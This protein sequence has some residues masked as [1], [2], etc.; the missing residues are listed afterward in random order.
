[1]WLNSSAPP[2]HYYIQNGDGYAVLKWTER[3]T[4]NETMKNTLWTYSR[5]ISIEGCNYTA[6]TKAIYNEADLGLYITELTGLYDRIAHQLGGVNSIDEAPPPAPPSDLI[7]RVATITCF[8]NGNKDLTY[9]IIAV[10]YGTDLRG[11]WGGDWGGIGPKLVGIAYTNELMSYYDAVN[12]DYLTGAINEV[13]ALPNIFGIFVVRIIV[14]SATIFGVANALAF[15]LGL[16]TGFNS[17][18]YALINGLVYELSVI[19]LFKPSYGSTSITRRITRKIIGRNPTVPGTR[20]SSLLM[21]RARRGGELHRYVPQYLLRRRI[22][23]ATTL[24][25]IHDGLT[26]RVKRPPKAEAR[27]ISDTTARYIAWAVRK[28]SPPSDIRVRFT[29]NIYSYKYLTQSSIAVLRSDKLLAR[30]IQYSIALRISELHERDID[31]LRSASFAKSGNARAMEKLRR[32][33]IV[34]NGTIDAAR[35]NRIK[36]DLARRYNWLGGDLYSGRAPAK[37]PRDPVL[38][39]MVSDYLTIHRQRTSTVLQMSV[40]LKVT[41]LS[42]VMLSLGGPLSIK[43][44]RSGKYGENHEKLAHDGAVRDYVMMG[45]EAARIFRRRS[46][47]MEDDLLSDARF[48]SLYVKPAIDFLESYRSYLVNALNDMGLPPG[49]TVH[50]F[51]MELR[52]GP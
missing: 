19:F 47:T 26:G 15:V 12:N 50:Q 21:S 45:R 52:T 24:T 14:L 42:A 43:V 35:I 51:I 9:S 29:G 38:R 18:M 40:R 28:R 23:D 4:P 20:K 13:K 30:F 36:E 6:L 22:V 33:G 7:Q 17:L 49:S 27:T 48:S 1:M 44:S 32:A 10:I 8:N 37:S 11:G 34:V 16:P 31:L 25:L 39:E 3:L 41:P 5:N 46:R 2:S